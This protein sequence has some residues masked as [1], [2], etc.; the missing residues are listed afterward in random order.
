METLYDI[1][2]GVGSNPPAS[3]S[4]LDVFIYCVHGALVQ[5]CEHHQLCVSTRSLHK[6]YS[7]IPVPTDN[8]LVSSTLME[9]KRLLGDGQFSSDPLLPS[10]LYAIY[11]KLDFRN[12]EDLVFLGSRVIVL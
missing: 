1:Y 5:V 11:E 8:F 6:W 9:A 12:Q 2:A 4:R 3:L 10:H 7:F